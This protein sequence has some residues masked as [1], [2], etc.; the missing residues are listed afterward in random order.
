VVVLVLRAVAK[1]NPS[2]RIALIALVFVVISSGMGGRN[3]GRRPAGLAVLP[4]LTVWAWEN[5]EDLRALDSH[6]YA[7][8]YLDQTIFI[9]PR[10]WSRPRLQRLLVPP[11]TRIIAVVRIEAG[12]AGAAI[13]APGLP[14]QVAS[15]IERSIQKPRTAMLQ[16]D[17]DATR[18]QRAFYINL[19]REVRK[20][21]PEGMPLSITALASWCAADDWISGLPVDEAVPMFF[22]MGPDHPPTDQPGWTYPLHEPLC[23]TSAGVSTDEPWP[24]LRRDQRVYVF[25]PGAW[26]ALAIANMEALV[27]P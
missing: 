22:R 21:L 3:G 15:L 27:K 9:S 11:T 23:Q 2:I 8:A 20:R 19:L 4:R 1:L 14:A 7:V 10:V 18:S 17:F 6:R 26:T 16:I 24:A 25:H 13:D 5:P 12:A